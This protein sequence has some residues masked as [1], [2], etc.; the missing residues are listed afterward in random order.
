MYLVYVIVGGEIKIDHSKMEVIM[1]WLILTN[2]FDVRFFAGVEQYLRK[3][4]ALLF[5]I[6]KP[7]HTIILSGRNL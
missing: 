2:L 5:T 1:K 7:F 3:F 4:I 6:E